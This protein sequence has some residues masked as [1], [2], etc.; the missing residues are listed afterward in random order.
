[1]EIYNVLVE[2]INSEKIKSLG[3]NFSKQISLNESSGIYFVTVS[4]NEKQYKGKL[5]ME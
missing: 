3:G 4:D 1:M 2:T 5:V